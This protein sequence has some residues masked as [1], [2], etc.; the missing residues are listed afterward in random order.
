MVFVQDIYVLLNN[1]RTNF[2]GQF[3]NN[4]HIVELIS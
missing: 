4:E 3:S 2:I 1:I